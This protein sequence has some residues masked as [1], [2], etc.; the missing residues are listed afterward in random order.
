[1]CSALVDICKLKKECVRLKYSKK[2]MIVIYVVPEALIHVDRRCP[3]VVWII[4]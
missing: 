2:L 4:G 1:M 3:G